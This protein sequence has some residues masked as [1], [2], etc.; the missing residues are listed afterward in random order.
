MKDI[1]KKIEDT[2]SDYQ[3]TILKLYNKIAVNNVKIY[4]IE[5]TK[6]YIAIQK[7]LDNNSDL[8]VELAQV[9]QLTNSKLEKLDLEMG[10]LS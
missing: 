1:N 3:S 4:S 9:R 7:L 8:Q 10:T 6:D 2:L 5:E